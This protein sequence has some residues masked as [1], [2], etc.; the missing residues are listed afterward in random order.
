MACLLMVTDGAQ[1]LV[2]STAAIHTARL[3]LCRCPV[4]PAQRRSGRQHRP[5]ELVPS[6]LHR[7]LIAGIVAF[8]I[9]EVTAHAFDLRCCWR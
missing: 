9:I 2:L 3:A 7:V 6:G 1:L 5:T 8:A 4:S